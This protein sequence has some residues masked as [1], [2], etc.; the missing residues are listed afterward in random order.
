[1]IMTTK[2][3]HD[4]KCRDLAKHFLRDEPPHD[5]EKNVVQL[6]WTI[7]NTIEDRSLEAKCNYVEPP[8][9][10]GLEG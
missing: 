2:S 1:M 5:N 6:A 4:H 10:R 8:D 7:Q 3:T 9:P